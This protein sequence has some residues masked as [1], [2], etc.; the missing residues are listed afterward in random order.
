[1][2]M[3]TGTSCFSSPSCC[4]RY[5][6]CAGATSGVKGMLAGTGFSEAEEEEEEDEEENRPLSNRG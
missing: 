4:C 2:G 3:P 1:M 5:P 6:A